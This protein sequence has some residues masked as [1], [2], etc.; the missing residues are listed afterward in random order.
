MAPFVSKEAIKQLWSTAVV[1]EE[2]ARFGTKYKAV[3]GLGW[4]IV[5]ASDDHGPVNHPWNGTGR[6]GHTGA[7]SGFD[8]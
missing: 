1:Y 6:I 5:H 4:D 8:E 3:Y 2:K 7:Q